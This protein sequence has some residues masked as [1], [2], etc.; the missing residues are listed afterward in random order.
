VQSR[1]ITTRTPQDDQAAE[2]LDQVLPVGT[3]FLWE[4]TEISEIAPRPNSL[5]L[6]VLRRIY[7]KNG[8]VQ[9]TYASL[10]IIYEPRDFLRVIGGQ[11]FV[12]REEELQSL[13]PAYSYLTKAR[14][15]EPVPAR[16]EGAW[17]SMKNAWKLG[18]WRMP[19]GVALLERLRQADA[20]ELSATFA[21]SLDRFMKDYELIFLINLCA[22]RELATR[23]V[24]PT[25]TNRQPPIKTSLKGNSLDFGD[26][27][28]FHGHGLDPAPEHPSYE[29]LRE[30][31]RYLTVKHVDH[32][33]TCAPQ[34]LPADT[35]DFPIRGMLTNL[36]TQNKTSKA[37]GVSPGVATGTARP[38]EDV[39]AHED[40]ILVTDLL[41]PDLAPLLPYAQGIVSRRG[42]VLSHLAIIAREQ[43]IPVVVLGEGTSLPATG[44]RIA[45]NGTDGS[46]KIL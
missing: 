7:G 9:N 37:M 1:P 29:W 30:A 17:R 21:E 36:P 8:P 19:S 44:T 16:G 5:T 20:L 31:A 14:P 6:D 34:A 41:T 42:G 10:G 22:Q 13:L 39:L 32:I 3:P 27:T 18:H 46:I 38:R 43:G 2:Y 23:R 35:L 45:I 28:P 12:D 11:L 25:N 4:T 24:L 33:R 26:E 15:G 40:S